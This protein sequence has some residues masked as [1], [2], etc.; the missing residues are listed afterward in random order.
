MDELALSAE[1]SLLRL[2]PVALAITGFLVVRW[3]LAVPVCFYEGLGGR[4]ALK[5]SGA[6]VRGNER[7]R[8]GQDITPNPVETN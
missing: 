6:L 4:P 5:R 3:S 8:P 1:G 2:S 7:L